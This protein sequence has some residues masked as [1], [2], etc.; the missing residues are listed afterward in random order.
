LL[1]E[2]AALDDS[3]HPPEGDATS[4]PPV[5]APPTPPAADAGTSPHELEPVRSAPRD[6]EPPASG[7]RFVV[8]L[9]EGPILRA[10]RGLGP[11]MKQIDVARMRPHFR[12]SFEPRLTLE[13]GDLGLGDLVFHFSYGLLSG[14]VCDTVA[15]ASFDAL[16]S[17]R[18]LFA[19]A[20]GGF[21]PLTELDGTPLD[22]ME[23]LRGRVVSAPSGRTGVTFRA[24]E[25]PKGLTVEAFFYGAEDRGEPIYGLEIRVAYGR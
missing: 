1:L 4:P 18:A 19:R 21:G 15:G 13:L 11:W 23:E 5:N 6:P 7:S 16:L 12:K 14:A 9:E 3:D 22:D 8:S 20:L 2:A 24:R 25:A 17:R 10:T